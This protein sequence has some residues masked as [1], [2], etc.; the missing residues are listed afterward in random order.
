MKTFLVLTFL[1]LT[2]QFSVQS[3]AQPKQK[4]IESTKDKIADKDGIIWHDPHQQPFRLKG[5]KWIGQEQVYR[6]LPLKPQRPIRQAVSDLADNTSGG[7]I[8]FQTD[9]P[10]IRIRAKLSSASFMYHMPSTGQS[11]FDLYSGEP[12][13]LTYLSTARLKPQDIEFTADLFND[14]QKMRNFVINFPLYNGVES[15]EIGIAANTVLSPPLGRQDQ[16]SIVVY[17]TSITQ[18]CCAARPGLSYTNILSRRLNLE[19]VNLGFS[20]NG[21]GEPELAH[22]INDI[23]DKKLIILDYE[24][25]AYQAITKTLGPFIDILRK[26]DPNVN[27]LIISKILFSEDIHQPHIMA[28]F[29][30]RSTFQRDLVATRKQAGDDHI[31]FLDGK[32]LLGEYADEA[33]VDGVHLTSYGFMMMANTIQPVI[34]K[35]LKR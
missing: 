30:V 31:F 8:H 23:D 7:Q 34:E 25:N 22:L 11:S 28:D 6:R 19:F 20:G 13:K 33:T 17:G 15:V 26:N 18:G 32:T 14:S 24:A 1:L 12:G 5:F 16:G 2:L 3:L 27:I 29:N 10:I 35:I 4:A 21:W 9:S